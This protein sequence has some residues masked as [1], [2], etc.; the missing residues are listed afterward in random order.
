MRIVMNSNGDKKS[1]WNIR[2][3]METLPYVFPFDVSTVFHLRM[4]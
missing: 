4:L 2:R 1:P 3:C